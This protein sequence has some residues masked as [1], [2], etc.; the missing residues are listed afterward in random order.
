MRKWY[1]VGAHPGYDC[2]KA[3][4]FHNPCL[5]FGKLH[6]IVVGVKNKW[7]GNKHPCKYADAGQKDGFIHHGNDQL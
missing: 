3:K 6:R 4:L 2:F 1:V 7:S 5:L